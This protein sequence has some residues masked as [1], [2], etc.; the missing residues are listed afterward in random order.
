VKNV[1]DDGMT[2][3]D[4]LDDFYFESERVRQKMN[5]ILFCWVSCVCKEYL[6]IYVAFLEENVSMLNLTSLC[7]APTFFS[8]GSTALYGPGPPRFVEVS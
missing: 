4:R 1:F 3:W 2:V 5:T 6:S 8:H 7:S